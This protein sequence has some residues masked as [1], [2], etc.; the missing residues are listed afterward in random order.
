[1]VGIGAAVA[2]S[3][4]ILTIL[5]FATAELCIVIVP[6]EYGCSTTALLLIGGAA[7]FFLMIIWCFL[8]A[9]IRTSFASK[10]DAATEEPAMSPTPT[11]EEPNARPLNGR[12][13]L[14][15]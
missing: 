6:S 11:A 14:V 7:F 8:T 3:A 9:A 15:L 13:P 10:H 5:L 2:P 12:A 1:M 4:V